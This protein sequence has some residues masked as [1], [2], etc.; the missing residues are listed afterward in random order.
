[1][2]AAPSVF[3]RS[4]PQWARHSLWALNLLFLLAL[5][6]PLWAGTYGPQQFDY[7]DGTTVLGDNSTIGTNVPG[8]ASV[9]GGA[10]R[11]TQST[12]GYTSSSYKLPNL[13]PGRVI[14]VFDVGFKVQMSTTATAADGWSLNFGAVPAGNGSGEG[15][16]VMPKGLVIAWDTYDNSNDVPSIEVFCNGISV[17][18]FPQTFIFDPDFRS[19]AIHWDADGLDV[20]YDGTVIC[21]NLPTPGFTPASGNTFAFSARTGGAAEDVYLDD[22]S[23]QTAQTPPLETGGPVISEFVAENKK[24]LEDED[25]ENPD[26][27]EIYNGQNATANLDGWHLTNVTDNPALW[28]L[29]AI[30]LTA[31]QYKV[32]YASGK[33][34]TAVAGPLHTNFTL[35]KEGGYVA[36][37]R[38]DNTVASEYVY[39][40]Q[41][42][43]ISYGEKGAGRTVGFMRPATPGTPNIAAVAAGPPAEDV[44]FSREGGLIADAVTLTIAP[45]STPGAVVRYTTNNTQ[46]SEGSPV[47]SAPFNIATST[48]IRARVFAPGRLPGNVSSR[49]FLLLDSTLTNYNGSGQIFSSPL[50]IVVLDSFGIPV[51]NYADPAVS[52]PYRLTYGVA[53]DRDPATGRASL[54]GPVNFQGRSGT[55]VR[56]ESSS[57]FA[58]KQYGWELWDEDNDDSGAP[59]LGLPSDSD[60]ILYGPYTDKTLMRNLLVYSRML[61]LRPDGS[62]MRT[63]F[64]EV[65][66]NQTGATSISYSTYRGVYVLI[67]KIKRTKNRVDLAKLNTLTTDPT[68]IT[69]GYIFKKDK[70]SPGNTK[71]N[72]NSGQVFEAQD[73]EVLNTAQLAYLKGYLNGFDTVLN[74]AGFADPVNGYAKY[75]DPLSFI[76]N[77]WFVEIT[78]QIDGYR[79]ST[80]FTKDRGGK[81]RCQ[82]LWDYNLSLSNAD[83]ATGDNP[84]G[85]YY[86]QNGFPAY[87]WWPRLRQDP[88]YLQL[89]WDRYWQL[90][91]GLFATDAILAEIDAQASMLLNGSTVPVGNNSAPAAPLVEN[92]V[93]RHYRRYPILGIYIWPNSPGYAQRTFFRSGTNSTGEIDFMKNWLTQR[94]AWIDD[95]NTVS[96]KI[97][98]PPNFS[99]SGGIV[100]PNS[101]VTITAYTGTPPTGLTYATGEIYYTTDGSDPRA[102]GGAIAG[103]LYSD[104]LTINSSTAVKARLYNAGAW[105]PLTSADFVVAAIP[106]DASNLAITE[107]MYNPLNPTAAEVAAGYLSANDFEYVELQ[108]L[109]STSIDLTGVKFTE[110]ITFD[111]TGIDPAL[112]TVAPGARVLVVANRNAFLARYGN[113]PAVQIT[114]EYTGSLSNGGESITL[115]A[116]DGTVVRQFT[117][118]D[119]AP[120][121][122]DANGHGYSLVPN[123]LASNSNL[124]VPTSWHSSAQIGGTP[125]LP[126]GQPFTGSPNADTDGDGYTDYFE[127]ATGSDM[128]STSSFFA[129]Q[130][131]FETYTVNNVPGTYLTYEFHQNLA[132]DGVNCRVELSADLQTW[133]SDASVVTFVRTRNIGDGTALVTWRS[134]QP[135]DD[136]HPRMFMRLH[137]QP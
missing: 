63:K 88:N 111:F 20:T 11:L 53:I 95:Q 42:E 99:R 10:L 107:I 125:G 70:E 91:R 93:M 133:Q 87:Y 132:A 6:D 136:A 98:R 126:N 78:K 29:P 49:T 58:Q 34:R 115:L 83:Y 54:T 28:T 1:M 97:Y 137:V 106:A 5:A 117:Y 44:A 50:P 86:S 66:F 89:H 103:T 82:P 102:P 13:D 71:I 118:D 113:N 59:L 67:E 23:V 64:C 45:P 65:F 48:T 74:G 46:P 120:W 18:N 51:D 80:Y 39:G 79:L 37:T 75:I 69:G 17:A 4:F 12:I 90:R 105:S 32:I 129:P 72:L 38:P 7:S 24:S 30:T 101:D 60:W 109:G 116:L 76:D 81:L 19:V 119:A 114:G 2:K 3:K 52:R 26:W 68:M 15:G 27:I 14:D 33:N 104:K 41:T 9:Q 124:N 130:Y 47:Y 77:Q 100:P 122:E 73:P 121:P 128:T 57:G 127:Y 61:A 31:Y 35:Q 16:F 123:N 135:L 22:L 85:W 112:R 110:G 8:A 21:N 62:A 55:H 43:D 96:G 131:R 92:P 56:G 36:L 108:N 94:L 40:P 25:V 134:A 84:Q